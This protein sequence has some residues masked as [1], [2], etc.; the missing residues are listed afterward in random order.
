MRTRLKSLL[1]SLCLCLPTLSWAGNPSNV[2][3]YTVDGIQRDAAQHVIGKTICNTTN[4]QCTYYAFDAYGNLLMRCAGNTKNVFQYDADG[5]LIKEINY[6][7]P[8]GVS[9][10]PEEEQYIMSQASYKSGMKRAVENYGSLPKADEELSIDEQV[11]L[12]VQREKDKQGGFNSTMRTVGNVVNTVGQ[13][14]NVVGQLFDDGEKRRQE[15]LARERRN[16]IITMSV[17]GGLVLLIVV[18]LLIVLLKK[19]KPKT[20]G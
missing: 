14:A 4:G 20:N 10:Y 6:T 18:L 12:R 19:E 17:I 13:V 1:Y 8:E 11:N 3:N 9:N 15:E 16:N 2:P 7:Y 5:F